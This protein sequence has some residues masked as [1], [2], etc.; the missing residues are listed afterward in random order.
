[1]RAAE[2]LPETQAEGNTNIVRLQSRYHHAE[3]LYEVSIWRYYL[4]PIFL[5]TCLYDALDYV[6]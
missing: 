6:Y 3:H 5:Q 2:L 1:M 4:L